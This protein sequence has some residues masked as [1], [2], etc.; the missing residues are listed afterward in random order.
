MLGTK[1]DFPYCWDPKVPLSVWFPIILTQS[2]RLGWLQW[3]LTGKK[4]KK[5]GI[6]KRFCVTTTSRNVS[7]SATYYNQV[8]FLGGQIKCLLE[9]IC[10]E[11]AWVGSEKDRETDQRVKA[12]C[13][14]G[15]LNH[16]YVGSFSGFP[17]LPCFVW[18]WVPVGL[19]QG[20]PCAHASFSQGEMQG[21][22]G[23]W[24]DLLWSGSLSLLWP[25]RNVSVPCVV[26][27]EVSFS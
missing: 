24:Q 26:L 15:G 6:Q 12:T 5:K 27:R 19:T 13:F 11:K 25:L 3:T 20:F 8:S 2:S 4:K 18:P 16:L 17:R 7:P 1:L 9:K 10:A 23:S 21:F 22:L 14:R